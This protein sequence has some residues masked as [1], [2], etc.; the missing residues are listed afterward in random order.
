MHCNSASRCGYHAEDGWWCDC[1]RIVVYECLWHNYGEILFD[2]T[3][4]E[5]F[6]CST[7]QGGGISSVVKWSPLNWKDGCL[8]HDHWVN[9]C[10]DLWARKFTPTAP[11]RSKFQASAYRQLLSP[12][13]NKTK[14]CKVTRNWVQRPVYSGALCNDMN[15]GFPLYFIWKT[16]IRIVW[17]PQTIC[18]WLE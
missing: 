6:W 13:S 1:K 18:G 16:S 15:L 5:N 17:T 9:C 4:L 7:M 11:A 14:T 12:K 8:I 2:A 3:E 10:S